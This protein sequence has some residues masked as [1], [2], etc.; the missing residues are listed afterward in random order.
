MVEKL[1]GDRLAFDGGYG[2]PF[3]DCQESGYYKDGGIG[4]GKGTLSNPRGSLK[5]RRL[6]LAR[7]I[8]KK[9]VSLC[10]VLVL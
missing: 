2:T 10:V 5:R 9:K 1:D 4:E 8:K 3:L 7:S 6:F